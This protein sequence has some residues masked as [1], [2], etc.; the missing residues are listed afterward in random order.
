MWVFIN[1]L[2]ELLFGSWFDLIAAW[3][4][5]LQIGLTALPLTV[6]ALLIYRWV[7]D[8]AGIVRT[9][10]RIKAYL[11]ELWLYKDDPRVLLGAQ[12]RVFWHSLVYLK[13]ALLPVAILLV[14]V[15]LLTAQVESRFALRA[16]DPGEAVLVGATVAPADNLLRKD[17]SITGAGLRVETPPLRVTATGEVLWRVSSDG[18]G[19]RV[20]D[21][22][23][24]SAAA[25]LDLR[26]AGSR[27]PPLAAEI[28]PADDWRSLAHP[29]T[30]ALP[31][32]A[33]ATRAPALVRL[34]IDYPPARGRFAGLSSASWWLLGATLL[35]GFTIR[36]WFGVTF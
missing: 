22:R 7:S 14:P 2:S 3:P 35:I 17:A 32:A 18:P 8:Q 31:A 33:G 28:F 13:H 16:P 29:A 34:A 6:L 9:K 27:H 24:G 15:G 36:R 20:L 11:L 4:D 19:Q 10:D 21:V 25:A 26:V 23:V 30:P 12:G 5:W 1:R